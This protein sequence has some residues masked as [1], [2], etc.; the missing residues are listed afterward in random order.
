MW[1]V[2]SDLEVGWVFE[3]QR[4]EKSRWW[5]LSD[6]QLGVTTP[7]CTCG[8]LCGQSLV[9]SRFLCLSLGRRRD[10][11][12]ASPSWGR[13]VHLLRCAVVF[14][15][16]CVIEAWCGWVRVGILRTVDVLSDIASNAV[17]ANVIEVWG[18]WMMAGLCMFGGLVV[19][20][21]W[22]CIGICN[23]WWGDP[24]VWMRAVST[25]TSVVRDQLRVYYYL[26]IRHWGRL[27]YLD[28]CG[29]QSQQRHL[30]HLLLWSK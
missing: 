12:K 30:P 25:W 8:G 17:T 19:L 9:L 11:A 5:A 13:T 6:R 26:H 18:G 16:T 29:V 27:V 10:G 20:G 22:F 24:L 7:Q 1:V 2:H 4:I 3:H 23:D 21:V 14:I 28:S 15:V